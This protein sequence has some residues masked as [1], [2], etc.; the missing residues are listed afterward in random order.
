VPRVP[1]GLRQ[2]AA[3]L[4]ALAAPRRRDAFRGLCR[5]QTKGLRLH[6][7]SDNYPDA[8]RAVCSRLMGLTREDG[9]TQIDGSC[10][11]G[12]RELRALEVQ[13]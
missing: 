13:D 5:T 1:Q 12:A 8:R 10:G 4:D 9:G 7:R 3:P 6:E 2:D 11:Q